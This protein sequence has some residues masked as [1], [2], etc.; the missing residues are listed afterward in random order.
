MLTEEVLAAGMKTVFDTRDQTGLGWLRLLR[1]MLAFPASRRA[2][3]R[4]AGPFDI[5]NLGATD[6]TGVCRTVHAS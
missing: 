6:L 3:F 1:K 5:A 4:A 2:P